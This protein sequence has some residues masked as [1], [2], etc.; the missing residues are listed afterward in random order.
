M[1]VPQ[2]GQSRLDRARAVERIGHPVAVVED[3]HENLKITTPA[4][5]A[6]AEVL[7]RLQKERGRPGAEIARSLMGSLGN[8]T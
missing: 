1:K 8:S 2:D 7:L 4:D 5:L 6:V 3:S